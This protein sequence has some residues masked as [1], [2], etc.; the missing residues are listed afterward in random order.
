MNIGVVIAQIDD[1]ERFRLKTIG[2]YLYPTGVVAVCVNFA[3][4]NNR[5]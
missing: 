3:T 1:T 5:Q 2:I 4:Q